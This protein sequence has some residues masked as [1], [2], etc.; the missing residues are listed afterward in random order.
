MVEAAECAPVPVD[1]LAV[2][3]KIALASSEEGQGDHFMLLAVKDGHLVGHLCIERVSYWYAPEHEFLTDFGFYVLPQHRNTDVEQ[4]LL[5]EAARVAT[6]A[7]L[8][9]TIFVNN[10]SRRRGAHHRIEKIAS[11]IRYVP[12]G[13]VYN[14]KARA[15]VLGRQEADRG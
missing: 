3:R 9:L 10:P 11:L 13:A 2:A 8:P 4:A 14:V 12:A 15:R 7:G 1:P 6:I 5:E